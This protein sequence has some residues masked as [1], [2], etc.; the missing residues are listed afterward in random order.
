MNYYQARISIETARLL[1]KMRIDYE[2][3]IGGNVTKGDCLI[4]AFEDARW[5]DNYDYDFI[6]KKIHSTQMPVIPKAEY[7]VSPSAQMLKIQI[8]DDVKDGI[9]K[10]KEHLPSIIGTRSV[11]V[12]VCI[13][14]ILKAAYIK[15]NNFY[16]DDENK[17]A[18]ASTINLPD[19]ILSSSNLNTDTKDTMIALLE[20]SQKQMNALFDNLKNE[21]SKLQ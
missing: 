21:L 18:Q 15:E 11:T 8:T 12:G 19:T 5:T 6:W 13:R 10:L 2:K 1:E 4:R 17:T 3:K 9:Q 14:E 16:I 7:E 20:D